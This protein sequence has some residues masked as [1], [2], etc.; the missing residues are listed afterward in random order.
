MS[1]LSTKWRH[2]KTGGTYEIVG[3]NAALQCSSYPEVEA[4]LEDDVF[5]IYRNVRTGALYIRPTEE[6]MDG[7]FERVPE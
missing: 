5:T 4:A 6:F 2:K 1:D 7:R 3:E